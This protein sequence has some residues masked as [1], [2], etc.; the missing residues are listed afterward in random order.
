[1]PHDPTL[2]FGKHRGRRVSQLPI[3]YLRWL[4]K[5]WIPRQDQHDVKKAAELELEERE[6]WLRSTRSPPL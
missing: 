4:V 2:D 3:N 1:M 5:V 6:A